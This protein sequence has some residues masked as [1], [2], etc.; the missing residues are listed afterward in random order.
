MR[1]VHTSK[2]CDKGNDDALKRL[3]VGFNEKSEMK[4]DEKVVV[5][6]G[7]PCKACMRD[8]LVM[9]GPAW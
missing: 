5:K 3:M 7:R 2:A 1:S 4:N 8:G 6:W 9:D